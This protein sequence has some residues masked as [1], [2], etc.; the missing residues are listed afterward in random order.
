MESSKILSASW[1]DLLFDNRNKDYGAYDLRRTYPGRVK[2]ALFLTLLIS[3]LFITV[4][5]MGNGKQQLQVRS[6]DDGGMIITPITETKPPEPEP[7]PVVQQRAAEPVQTVI[8]TPPRIV[9]NQTIIDRPM[10]SVDDLLG[11]QV[12]TDIVDGIPFTGIS[13]PSLPG[14]PTGF[15]DA[16]K[17]KESD[18]PVM[19][20]QV[21][22]RFIGDWVKFLR[23]HL[24]PVVPLDNGAP[25]G[26]YTVIVQFVVDKEGNVSDIKPL[27]NIG[28]GM[29]EEAVRVLKKA[30]RWEPAIQNG[31]PVKAYHKQPITFEV[32]GEE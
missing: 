21:Q 18:D 12:G 10:A 4:A 13:Q 30:T 3:A 1:L 29:E 19:I 25:P 27:T 11:A 7:E 5:G 31:Y 24:D 23:R 9:D 6:E 2:K 20:V 16:K 8:L 28:Y 32:I 17:D 22:S 14:E 15:I 26:R